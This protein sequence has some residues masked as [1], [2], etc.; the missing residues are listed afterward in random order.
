MT[1]VGETCAQRTNQKHNRRSHALGPTI[2]AQMVFLRKKS[3]RSTLLFWFLTAGIAVAQS[4]SI[5]QEIV[6]TYNF[7]PHLLSNQEINK[8]SAVLDQFWSRAKA[9]KTVYVPALREELANF[10]NPPFFLYDGSALLLSLSD[11]SADRR[12]ALA[13]MAH[14]DLRDVQVKDY[15][16]QVHRMAT[17]NEDTTAAAFRILEQPKF[18]VFIPQHSLTLAQ[19]YVL[20]YMLLPTDQAYW[21]QPAMDRLKTEAD[22]TAQKSLILLLW[23]AQTEAADQAIAAFEGDTSKAAAVREYGKQIM[24]AR[25]KM[26]AKQR[27]EA[28]GITEESLRQKRRERMKAVSDE[29]LIDLDDYTLT[30]A[31]MRK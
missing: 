20:V 31:A 4:T 22:E 9:Q 17:L 26:A 18:S 29:A 24:Q 5:H 23:Y 28:S 2:A 8:K 21:L 1:W 11:T 13:A 15:F 19:N 30:L 3:R 6:D 25:D 14:C 7:Q 10:K 12:I 27:A 16:Y